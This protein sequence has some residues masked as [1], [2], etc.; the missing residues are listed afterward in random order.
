MNTL[1]TAL[2]EW[3]D[4]DVSAHA[5]AQCLGIISPADP[6]RGAKA[7]YWSNNSLGNALHQ[8][9]EELVATGVLEKREVPDIQYRWG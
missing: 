6:M 4:F 3:T 8:I 1:R 2:V 5:L 7:V 9:L